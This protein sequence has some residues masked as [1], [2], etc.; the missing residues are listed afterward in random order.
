MKN[1]LDEGT[2][3]AYLDGELSPASMETAAAHI[4]ACEACAAATREA[5]TELSMFASAFAGDAALVVPTARLR[6]GIDTRI[7]GLRPSMP[8]HAATLAETKRPLRRWFAALVAPFAFTPARATAFASLAAFV[9]VGVIVAPLFMRQRTTGDAP[10]HMATNKETPAAVVNPAT[11][12]GQGATTSGEA[13][14]SSLQAGIGE[15][16]DANSNVASSSSP[17]R[18]D[19][20]ALMVNA[21]LKQ[22][23][24]RRRTMRAT[25]PSGERINSE[26]TTDAKDLALPGEENYLIAIASLNRVI[27]AG[28][29]ASM[30]PALRAD[31]ERNVADLDQAIS[32]SRRRALRN[33]Q[34]KDAAAFLF[35][36]YQSKVELLRTVADQ[37]QMAMLGR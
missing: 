14:T 33:P 5:E 36:A 10:T 27:E 7:A 31:L 32:A 23:R 1:C 13:A 20:G 24:V 17:S 16:A 9:I 35:A 29:D 22:A 4:A 30:R 37:S 34:D 28:G 18:S 19:D 12:I 2:L 6:E 21:G 26:R 25:T 11:T 15:T 3:Q 8:H